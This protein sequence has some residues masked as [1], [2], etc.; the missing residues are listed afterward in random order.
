MFKRIISVFLLCSMMLAT[1]SA[2]GDDTTDPAGNDTGSGTTESTT[3]E[4]ETTEPVDAN[5]FLLDTLPENLDFG[6]SDV[7]ILI[8]SAIANSEF[9]VEEQTGETVDD[10][11]YTRNG[12]IENRL[13]VHLNFIDIPG[14]W[15][16]RETFNGTIRNSVAANDGAYDL[17]AVLSNQLSF[18][19]LE[20]LLQNLSKLNYLDFEQPWW[21]NGLLDELSVDGKL[22][23]VSG[24]ASLGLVKGMMCVY[25]NKQMC[26][27]NGITGLEDLV[28]EGTWTIDKLAEYASVVYQDLDQNAKKSVDDLFGLTTG[29]Y[30]QLY[31][32]IDSFNLQILER[33]ESGYPSKF[34]YD[35]E[36]VFDAYSKLY[37]LFHTNN[38][39]YTSSVNYMSGRF[40]DQ[41]ALFST[42]EFGYADTYRDIETFD[43]GVLPFP[44]YDED[45]KDYRT[46][47]RAT[48]SSFCMPV[49]IEEPDM[50]AAVLECFAS[51]SYRVVSPAYFEQALKLKYSRDEATSA[52][53]DIIKSSVTFSFATSFTSSI[54]DPQ[55][56]FK[57]QLVQG[58]QNWMS[59]MA[60]WMP[61]SQALLEK[62]VQTLRE[63]P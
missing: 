60:S 11:L 25:Y 3:V 1:F 58:T 51:E 30:N 19:T 50:A 61:P 57:Q 55:N 22:Y 37:S 41:H 20:G 40:Q 12:N 18:L 7:N 33:D 29:D 24:D 17:C 48:Y 32:F 2:C 5:G 10:A 4:T 27:D 63:L 13:G 44:K 56:M 36:R 15:V 47:A 21:A 49:T 6:G 34:I 43:F 45:Q 35:N 8:R 38:S 9:Y 16:D 59:Y 54:G 42:G 14:E 26:E 53:F 31:G 52:I 39:F 62:T 46:T 23:F 28:Y